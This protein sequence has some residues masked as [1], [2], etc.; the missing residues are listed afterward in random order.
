MNYFK[1]IERLE[2]RNKQLQEENEKLRWGIKDAQAI[3]EKA[4]ALIA[5][6]NERKLEYD[7]LI[8]ELEKEKKEYKDLI[9]TVRFKIVNAE[10]KYKGAYK[11]ATKDIKKI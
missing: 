10:K 7:K 8:A 2:K 3:Q 11:K 1:K 5:A 4:E 6:T 9:N